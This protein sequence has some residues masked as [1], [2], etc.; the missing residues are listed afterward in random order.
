MAS[1]LVAG[2][3]ALLA[4]Q[5]PNACPASIEDAVKARATANAVK[6][7]GTGS[8]NLL[9]NVAD[10]SAVGT[11]VP[12]TPNAL[13]STI[14]IQDDGKILM[15]GQFDE[16]GTAATSSKGYILRVS[17]DGLI[18][19]SFDINFNNY[20]T[21]IAIQPDN[22]ILVVGNFTTVN[23]V[24]RNRIA[25]LNSDATLDTGFNPNANNEV[26]AIALQPDAK[27]LI[28]GLFNEIGGISR[29]YI[30]RLKEIVDNGPYQLI[31]TVPSNTNVILG[32]IFST[33]HNNFPVFYDIAVVPYEDSIISEKHYYI[34]DN[35]LQDN[36][37]E[38]LKDKLTLSVGDKIYVYSS[39]DENMS[40][41]IFGT[42]I[43]A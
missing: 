27:I 41:N 5:F 9:L 33:N 14:S 22:K 19:N 36:N 35:L 25:R 42:E 26:S 11:A 39:T 3:S 12:G 7:A 6:N 38:V 2:Y 16:I 37:F 28:I 10:V 13:V 21:E 43:T 15:G 31:Y 30:I 4:Q 8:P 32:S 29:Q 40:F 23:G 20:V 24:T 34:W 1:P 17:A 18:D